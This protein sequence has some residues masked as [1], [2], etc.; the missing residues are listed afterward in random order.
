MHAIEV[1]PFVLMVAVDEYRVI[2]SAL[3][4]VPNTERLRESLK[5]Q[6]QNQY[7]ERM[8]LEEQRFSEK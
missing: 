7:R 2:A 6:V 1:K 8:I 5:A 3:E 4:A